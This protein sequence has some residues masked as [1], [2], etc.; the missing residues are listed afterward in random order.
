MRLISLA[1]A[2]VCFL[3]GM[4]SANDGPG[5]TA[6]EGKYIISPTLEFET[7][8]MLKC[9]YA[10]SQAA[11]KT[12]DHIWFG[13]V[14]GK[15]TFDG[16]PSERLKILG[17][18]E[19][20]QYSNMFPFNSLA[21]QLFGDMQ[22]NDFYIRQAQ[23]IFSLVNRESFSLEL[24]LGLMPY[25]YNPEVRDLGEFL[26]RSGTYPFY[27]LGKFDEP[28]QRLTGLRVG[29][30]AGNE[31]VSW[32]FD[33]LALTE[34]EIRPF[35]DISLAA[36]ADVDI[37]K[38]IEVGGGVD[39]ARCIPTD[40]RITTPWLDQNG[41]PNT[42]C[43]Y[44]I[45]FINSDTGC[46]T[47]KA[48][49]LMTHAT[50]DPLYTL[51]GREGS[52]ISEL[53]GKNG[54]KIYGELAVIGLENY[55]SN[56]NPNPLGYDKLS[57]KMPW[58]AGITIPAWK[59]LDVCALEFE[60]Y[61][62]HYP[63]NYYYVTNVGQLRPYL[64]SAWGTAGSPYDS[65]GYSIDRWYWSLYMKKQIIRHFSLVCQIGRDIQRWEMFIAL[66]RNYDFEDAMVRPNQWGWHL[67]TVFDF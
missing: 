60:H 46:Y 8:E 41:N 42:N 9:R 61:P 10:A 62:C 36:I 64:G 11:S 40:G 28:Y 43:I 17:T 38:F 26:F 48:T 51:R 27:L 15:L 4:V 33:W 29:F 7:A 57:E 3:G 22:W 1:V 12:L 5:D 47:F 30:T 25:K 53:I 2:A 31:A 24:A 54:G 23:G 34:R 66:N 58:M 52:F 21:D 44:V 18:F 32:K 39:F 13:N 56:G 59:I 20:R 6:A 49:K 63:N 45:P 50:V 37:M 16:E 35:W 14:T 19:F 55:P 65:A 67:K